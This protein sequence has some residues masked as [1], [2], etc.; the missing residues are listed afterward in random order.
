MDTCVNTGKG[1]DEWHKISG[2]LGIQYDCDPISH[3]WNPKAPTVVILMWIYQHLT[4]VNTQNDQTSF[5]YY[6]YTAERE[7]TYSTNRVAKNRNVPSKFPNFPGNIQNIG[8]LPECGEL[9]VHRLKL[10]YTESRF[11]HSLVDTFKAKEQLRHFW[12]YLKIKTVKIWLH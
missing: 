7:V 6:F 4:V 9:S 2:K 10:V 1:T 8:N 12:D 3:L 11:L 5:L